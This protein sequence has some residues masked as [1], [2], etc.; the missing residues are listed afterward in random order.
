MPHEMLR[1][2]AV[3][4][5]GA[6]RIIGGGLMSSFFHRLVIGVAFVGAFALLAGRPAQAQL[7]EYITFRTTFPFIV[8][9]TTMP[10]GAYS[11]RR[12][13]DTQGVYL[14]SGPRSVFLQANP[15]SHPPSIDPAKDEV[16][17]QKFGD[18]FVMSE[19][20]EGD[21]STG[22]VSTMKYKGERV[23]SNEQPV[24][25]AVAAMR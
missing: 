7:A 6:G 21:D 5:P 18:Q 2:S 10:A 3:R 22:I 1:A 11:I 23:A 17:F 4:R 15:T 13:D 14:V 24:L 25:I 19:V 9:S 20:W 12:T 8:G 16:I